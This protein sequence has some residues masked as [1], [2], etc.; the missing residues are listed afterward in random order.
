MPD[1]TA[2]PESSATPLRLLGGRFAIEIEATPPVVGQVVADG[3]GSAVGAFHD[4]AGELVAVVT[5][6][7]GED[8]TGHFWFFQEGLTSAVGTTRVTELASGRTRTYHQ[9]PGGDRSIVD[10]TA[11]EITP[12]SC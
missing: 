5:V 3:D 10:T 2:S 8:I 9:N 6:A 12:S 4:S 1:R 11:F 7:N